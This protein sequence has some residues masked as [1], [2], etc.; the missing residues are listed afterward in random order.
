MT[1]TAIPQTNRSRGYA[2]ALISALIL[3]TTAIFIRHLTQTYQ[4]P[5]LVLA[6]WRDSFVVLTL[7]PI[8]GFPMGMGRFRLKPSPLPLPPSWDSCAPPCCGCNVAICAT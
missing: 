8:L 1:T 7:L 5:S 3:S 6:F 4:I 2:I